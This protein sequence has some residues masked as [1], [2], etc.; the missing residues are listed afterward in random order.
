MITCSSK[1][2]KTDL[3]F[4]KKLE[5]VLGIS[6]NE[7]REVAFEMQEQLDR[8]GDDGVL[9][10][11]MLVK[12]TLASEAGHT[13]FGPKPLTATAWSSSSIELDPRQI[14]AEEWNAWCRNIEKAK[15]VSSHFIL[16]KVQSII[17]YPE[18]GEI[19]IYDTRK[20][21]DIVLT[22]HERF[23]DLLGKD[24]SPQAVIESCHRT[25]TLK[26]LYPE[27]DELRGILLG[28]GQ[29]SSEAFTQSQIITNS[30]D[31]LTESEGASRLN[32]VRFKMLTDD[33]EA[34]H[35]NEHYRSLLPILDEL[36]SS[37]LLVGATLG[38][39]IGKY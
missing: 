7:I 36:Y 37:N 15:F 1:I 20:I 16:R 13:I 25:P 14:T 28:Y 22:H 26:E 32:I 27:H 21:K 17:D 19:L 8:L 31:C 5:K 12:L 39:W 35:L 18:I 29:K 30:N 33:A 38:K 4:S 2:N 10:G 6:L 9:I 11:S 3:I 34:V 23:K 24:I